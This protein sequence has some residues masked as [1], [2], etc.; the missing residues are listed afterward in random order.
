[1]GVWMRRRGWIVAIGVLGVLASAAAAERDGKELYAAYCADCH[2][3]DARGDGPDADLFST[4]PPSLRGDALAHE[5]DDALVERIRHGRPLPLVH[6]PAKLER[7]AGDV[8]VLVAYLHRLPTLRW[9]RI[10]RGEEL[11]VDRCEICHGP[12]GHPP[13]ALPK[14]VQ[15]RPQDLSDPAFQRATSDDTLLDRANRGHRGMPA[16]GGLDVP[17]NRDALI[18]YVRLLS[19]GYE[20]YSR[21]CA[22]C[23]GDDGRGP[24]TDWATEKRPTVVFDRAYFEKKDPEVLRRD[25]WHMLGDTEPR[26]PHMSRVLRPSDVRAILAYVRGLP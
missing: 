11:Y 19:P 5:S 12:F 13:A 16:I 1:M 24:G 25:V 3:A 23:H 2:G 22:G 4:P 9:S 7:R 26:M 21:F 6:D 18:A 20:R 8:D 14:G 10:E 17:A 15:R